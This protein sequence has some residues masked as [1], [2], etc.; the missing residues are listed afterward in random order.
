M[1]ILVSLVLVFALSTM[2]MASATRIACMGGSSNI[3]KDVTN[4]GIYPQTIIDYPDMFTGEIGGTAMN[5]I[6]AHYNIG[7][8]TLGLYFDKSKLSSTYAPNVD[9]DGMDLSVYDQKILLFYGM[10]MSGMN[11]GC[12]LSLFGNSHSKDVTG[13]PEDISEESVF[14][15]GLR[16]GVTLM[17]KLDA[18]L[19]FK[20]VSWT[21]TGS[22][23]KMVS[24]P[25]G[26]LTIGFGGRCWL[27]MSDRYTLIPYAGFS[28]FG[29]GVKYS[30]K[31]ETKYSSITVFIGAGNNIQIAEGVMVVSDFGIRLQP[32]A[33]D[34]TSPGGTKST[35]NKTSNSSLPYFRLGLEAD[36]T[37]WMKL[38]V[39]AY[40]DWHSQRFEVKKGP[41]DWGYANTTLCIGTGF[42]FGNLDIDCFLN[43]GFLTKGPYLLSGSGGKGNMF[44]QVSLKYIWAE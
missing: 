4:I 43:P 11:L 27:E 34:T 10:E 2:T 9:P 35:L 14:G 1:H 5:S 3:I 7:M 19:N 23:G 6:G 13:T 25:N 37:S 12:K 15:L 44:S 22:D 26:N 39:G 28:L 36:I 40:K 24:E 31:A 16:L 33:T 8:G 32:S 18:Y 17:E 42:H 21:H 30:S 41:E 29:E 38:R 20:T